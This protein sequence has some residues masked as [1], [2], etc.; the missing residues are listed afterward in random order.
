MGTFRRWFWRI[1]AVV[2]L[3]AVAGFLVFS[4]RGV[5]RAAAQYHAPVKLAGLEVDASMLERGEH[6]ANIWS[7]AECHGDNFGGRTLIDGGVAYVIAPNI[8]YGEGGLANDYTDED[9]ARAIR[10]GLA[11]DGRALFLMSSNDWTS[12]SDYDVESVI[13]FMKQ[14]P[15]I[16]KTQ[17]PSRLTPF[18]K[19]LAGIGAL[20]LWP[21]EHIDFNTQPVANHIPEPTAEYGAYIAKSCTGCHGADLKGGPALSPDAPAPPDLTS[22]GPAADWTRAQ[23]M[24]AITEGR[25]P[26]GHTMHPD[27]MPWPAFKHFTQVEREALSEYLDTLR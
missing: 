25:T 20:E 23:L 3:V 13:A 2:V 24:E 9:W 19:F 7:C 11:K 12:R 1:L 21:A 18:G 4:Q 5:K 10:Y 14:V 15:R 22:S 27:H 16:D 6:L 26:A 8:T 17:E